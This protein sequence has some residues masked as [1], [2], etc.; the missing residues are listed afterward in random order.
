MYYYDWTYVL[1]LIGAVIC[2]IAQAGVKSTYKKYS[3]VANSRGITGA[4]VAEKLLLNAGINDVSIQCVSGDLTDHYDP[5]NKTV[6]LSNA[7]YNGRSIASLSVA[8][9]ECGH[10]MQHAENYTPLSLRTTLVPLANFGSKLAWPLIIIG[11]LFARLGEISTMFIEVG[12]IMFSL[13]VLFQIVT[14]PVEFNASS[15]ALKCLQDQNW[16]TSDEMPGARKVLRA[17]AMTYVASAAAAILQLLRLI[18]ILNN[19]RSSKR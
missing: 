15:R 11:L 18:L 13:A 1:V 2:L 4:M 8:A 14:L 3:K 6:N 17:A 10:V 16:L 12:I 7:V 19:S 5:T 9:H